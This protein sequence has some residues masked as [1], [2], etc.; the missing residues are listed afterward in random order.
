LGASGRLQ[1]EYELTDIFREVEEEVRRERLE[2]LWKQYGDYAIAGVAVVV[3]AVSGFILWQ[4]YQENRRQQASAQYDAAVQ[5]AAANPAAAIEKFEY[6]AKNAPS[7]YATLAR[8][9]EAD[10]Y[11]VMGNNDKAIAIF[12]SLGNGSDDLIG[13]AARL[14]AAWAIV[15]TAPRKTVESLVAPLNNPASPWRFMAREVLAYADYRTGGFAAAQR[16]YETLANDAAA[17]ATLRARAR[18]MAALI[19]AGGEKDF[20]IVPPSA[21]APSPTSPAPQT[22]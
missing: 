12:E 2:K 21:P 22:P 14:R 19:K 11:L 20:G 3:I 7:G 17:P 9:A 10:T 1:K 15:D 6:L 13:S 5:L 4:R 16:E 8:F 18:G